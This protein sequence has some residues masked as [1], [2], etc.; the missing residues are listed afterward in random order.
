MGNILHYDAV[1][2]VFTVSKDVEEKLVSD[3]MKHSSTLAK[4]MAKHE[5]EEDEELYGDI[6]MTGTISAMDD[7]V[8]LSNDTDYS[9]DDDEDD[10]IMTQLKKRREQLQSMIV[11]SEKEQQAGYHRLPTRVKERKAK[12]NYLKQHIIPGK[13]VLVLDTNCFIG[14]IDL[15]TKLVHSAKWS[16]VVPLV[17]K[18]FILVLIRKLKTS[19]FVVIT[20]LDGLRSSTQK[21]GSAAQEAIKLIE[22]VLAKKQRQNQS[23]RVQTSH[24][25]FMSDISIRSEQFVFGETDKN[26]DDLVLS[27][28]LWWIAQPHDKNTVPVCL[29]TGDRN[30]SVKARARDVQVAP[31]SAIM[32]LT[33]K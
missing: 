33:P 22:G 18:S 2:E 17:G 23:L 29:V 12:L 20:E 8:L 14:H 9:V 7:D 3:H 32:Q 27:A 1:H 10:D 5:E 31:V 15:V 13:T 30:L 26:L 25:N 4:D 28:C 6:E 21:L 24:N 11:I 16:I 19:P